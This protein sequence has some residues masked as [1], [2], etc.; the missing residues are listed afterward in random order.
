MKLDAKFTYDSVRHDQENEIDLVLSFTAPKKDWEKERSPICVM[1]VIDVSGSMSGE[2]LDYAKKSALKLIDHLTDSDYCG[3]VTFDTNVRLVSKPL[4]MT[5]ENKATLQAK[6]GDLRCGSCTNFSGGLLTGLEEI[7]SSDLPK[8][9]LL[10]VIMLTD[11]LANVGVSDHE[12]LLALMKE[13]VQGASVSCFGYGQGADQELLADLAK[14]GDGNYAFIQNPDDA[15][16]AFAKELG[17]LLSTY[18]QDL[19]V[20]IEAKNGH[21]VKEVISDLEVEG[22]EKK[23][24][25]KFSN[26]LSEETRNIVIRTVLSEQTK[27]LPR[28]MTPFTV[29]VSYNVLQKDGSVK[30]ETSELK[31]KIKFVKPGEEQQKP[32][33]DLNEIVGLA[34]MVKSQIEAEEL[35]KSGDYVGAQS[36]MTK[37]SQRLRRRGL[38]KHADTTMRLGSNMQDAQLYAQSASYRTSA[39]Q[40]LTRSVGIASMDH[41]AS[42]DL[43]SLVGAAANAAQKSITKSFTQDEDK[44]DSIDQNKAENKTEFKKDQSEQSEFKE[45]KSSISKSRSKRW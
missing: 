19:Q 45:K 29:R 25:L 31:A 22:D 32:H 15:L 4:P 10:R 38:T 37:T 41:D 1:P 12:G 5:A 6:I 16:S 36:V 2:K 11:G 27:A 39:R 42:L 8:D 13:N 34:E 40:Q 21:Q 9:M 24:L 20:E 43:I 44:S 33:Q 35:A 28:K 7:K 18:A 30:S 23:A 3:V 14:V 17:G 26:I